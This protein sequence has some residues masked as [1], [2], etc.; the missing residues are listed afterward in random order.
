VN[1][2]IS[3]DMAAYHKISVPLRHVSSM[4]YCMKVAMDLKFKII[5]TSNLVKA[6]F[7]ALRRKKCLKFKENGIKLCGQT[8]KNGRDFFFNVL[9]RVQKHPNWNSAVYFV[10]VTRPFN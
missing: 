6:L 2:A 10:V 7:H 5:S 4:I 8:S 9:V 3:V 1:Y